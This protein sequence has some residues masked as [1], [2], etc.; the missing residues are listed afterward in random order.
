MNSGGNLVVGVLGAAMW[1]SLEWIRGTLFTGFGWNTLGIS[2]HPNVAMIQIA[3]ITGVG[4]LSFLIVLVN[5][6]AVITVKRL[7]VE[8]GKQ[9]LRPHYDFSVTIAAVALTFVYGVRQV[10]GPVPESQ[11][12]SVAIVQGNVPI[13]EKRDPAR[14]EEILEMHGKYSEAALALKPDLLIWPEAATPRPLFSDQRN[15][16]VVRGIAEKSDSDFLL[17]TVHFER[18]RPPFGDFNSVV[19]LSQRGKSAQF[20]HKMHLVPFGEYV[21]LRESFPLFAWIVGDLVPEDF[22]AGREPAILQMTKKPFRIG[23]LICFEDTLG[24]LARHFALRDAQLFVNVTNDGWFLASA[25]SRQHLQNALFRCAETKLPMV[26]AANTGVSCV[27]DAHGRIRQRLQNEDG[28]SFIEGLL[29]A[30]VPVL[31]DPKKT[32]YTLNGELFSLVCLAGAILG[33][34]GYFYR[35]RTA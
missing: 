23:A 15:W 27:I 25:G 22:D 17:G 32:F 16:D 8:A 3:D 12:L 9:K 26:R 33:G 35:R 5:L 28:N 18:E 13:M 30:E 2:L 24:D 6:I 4:G 21:P 20:Y 14:E 10:F 34:G 19:L 7:S 11:P 31:T 1:T 29:F